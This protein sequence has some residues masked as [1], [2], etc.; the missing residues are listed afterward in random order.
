MKALTEQA[1]LTQKK[2]DLSKGDDQVKDLARYKGELDRVN[3][4]IQEAQQ[5]HVRAMG[6]LNQQ[7]VL[8][9]KAYTDS[10]AAAL[11]TRR[12]A[13]AMD[14]A[15]AG[16]GDRARDEVRR[17]AGRAARGGLQTVRSLAVAVGN[18]ISEEVYQKELASLQGYL[19]ARVDAERDATAQITAAER[20]WRNGASRGI[21][22]YIEQAQNAG[23]C[24][25]VNCRQ[26]SSVAWKTGLCALP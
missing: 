2:I 12:D 3:A 11:K 25:R 13:M 19:T 4:Q 24:H 7:E 16:L 5:A 18:R 1:A 22:T 15:G 6:T 23:R 26:S 21:A 8:Q 17:L 9:V 10:L 14:V 20:D